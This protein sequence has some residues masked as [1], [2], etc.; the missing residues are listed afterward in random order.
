MVVLE[1][2]RNVPQNKQNS[3]RAYMSESVGTSQPSGPTI[4][5]NGPSPPYTLGAIA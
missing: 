5:Q 2:V 3:G 4:N 1:E